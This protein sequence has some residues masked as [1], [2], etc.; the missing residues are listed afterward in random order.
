MSDI[1]KGFLGLIF[2]SLK[3]NIPLPHLFPITGVFSAVSVTTVLSK[4]NLFPPLE[5]LL[6]ESDN[7]HALL[8]LGSV[9]FL[10]IVYAVAS[11]SELLWAQQYWKEL[12][13]APQM[14]QLIMPT[15][16]SGALSVMAFWT[17]NVKAFSLAYLTYCMVDTSACILY[18]QSI[19]PGLI[20]AR[21]SGS[22][23]YQTPQFESVVTFYIRRPW[24][25]LS[26]LK[27]SL[28]ILAVTLSRVYSFIDATYLLITI[29]IITNEAI[30]W[31]WRF[32][33]YR[34]H[35]AFGLGSS[36]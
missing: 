3:K 6:I 18:I 19:S 30:V 24:I 29:T 23:K 7:L 32:V 9:I 35:G 10:A 11:L 21:K 36:I 15:F 1:E 2:E 14:A 4:T 8:L 12:I 26:L 34:H 17:P 5:K 16:I 25:K 28:A 33:L 31:Y 13:P 22:P 27:F 20:K